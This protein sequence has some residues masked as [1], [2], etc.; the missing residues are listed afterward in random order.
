[1]IFQDL[2]QVT[3]SERSEYIVAAATSLG[4]SELIIEKDF[5]VV[6][7]LERLFALSEQLGPF[8]FKGGTSLSKG[9]RAIERF[10]EDIDISIGRATLGFAADAYFYEAGS[11]KETKRRIE[12]IRQK[13]RSYATG[14]LLPALRERISSELADDWALEAG[15]AGSLRFLY[16]TKQRGEIGY[17]KPDVLIEFG[18]ADSWPANDVEIRPY[19]VDALEAVTG[20]VKVHV[21][22][23]Q[24]TFWEKAT[25]LHEIAHR[26]E[27]LPFPARYSRHYYD[28]AL[29]SRSEI[30][31][32][33]VSNTELLSAVARFKSV[34][35]ASARAR[36]D[37]AKPGSL[38][39]MFPPF[40][41]EA[42]AA[43]YEQMRPMLFGEI[44]SFEDICDR[45]AALEVR[46]NDV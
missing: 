26:E 2:A 46:I 41:R 24:R 35:F 7:L 6:W 27:A 15:E 38:R 17:I 36:Y 30:G 16:P 13:V 19:V 25:I 5:W 28:L 23:P 31:T 32:A 10:S 14:A 37:L 39:L 42:V 33:A 22:D 1:M 44:P 40:R 8:T 20:S 18:H 4:V 43:D 21:L 12:E 45:I 11:V 9:F 3:L 29:L 34:F